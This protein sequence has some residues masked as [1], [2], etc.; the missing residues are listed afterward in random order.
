MRYLQMDQDPPMDRDGLNN[1]DFRVR[2]D[3]WL[4]D[5]GDALPPLEDDGGLN[6]ADFQ[7]EMDEWLA[8]A[9][10]PLEDDDVPQIVVPRT[11]GRRKRDEDDDQRGP[12]PKVAKTQMLGGAPKKS[13]KHS[14][15]V[16]RRTRRARNRKRETRARRRHKKARSRT[17]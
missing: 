16:K 14:K 4:A 10:P 8:D 3:G 12:T 13:R 11:L 9:Q 17:R 7:V 2:M 15:R 1:D 6:N 5:L